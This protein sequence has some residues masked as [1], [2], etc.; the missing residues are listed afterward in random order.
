M[1]D[2]WYNKEFL[3]FLLKEIEGNKYYKDEIR[4][5]KRRIDNLDLVIETSLDLKNEI[6]MSFNELKVDY[7]NDI[8]KFLDIEHIELT[9]IIIVKDEERCIKRCID[10]IVNEV[11]KIIIIDT[12]STDDT[13]RIIKELKYKKIKIYNYTWNN[14]F[15]EAR[16]FGLDKVNNGWIIFIDADEY[17]EENINLRKI[18]SEF[19]KIKDV[20]NL[21]IC[22][23]IKN[24]NDDNF[25]TVR[26]IFTKES[27]IRF[28]GKIHEE[29]RKNGEYIHYLSLNIPINHDGYT[30][31]V[32]NSKKKLERNYNLLK[33]MILIEKDNPRWIYFFIR[34]GAIFI[35]EREMEELAFKVLLNEP[36]KGLSIENLI[37]NEY[38]FPILDILAKRYLQS[39]DSLKLN[40]VIEVIDNIYPENTNTIY[41][42]VISKIIEMKIQ[43]N[44]LLLKVIDYRKN[45][46]N[47]C[48]GM[49]HSKGYHIDFL[50]AILL[51]ETANYKEA[52]KYFDFLEDK[53]LDESFVNK[54]KR[55][56]EVKSY[57]ENF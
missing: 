4:M 13:I 35:N 55:I 1:S 24:P 14:D 45:N 17:L 26:R 53:Y 8:R 18:I 11:D 38:T 40:K 56:F 50:I 5:I 30:I 54:Y 21:T 6:N 7:K 2:I 12:G 31:E 28:W 49:I 29:P 48:P 20:S 22:P 32:L 23:S 27:N 52:F 43:V 57:Y 41:Y 10:S 15:S 19:S 51:F 33:E 9:A 36:D 47:I 46:Y 34:D 16:N 42:L 3:N 44:E 37:N 25:I 39:N